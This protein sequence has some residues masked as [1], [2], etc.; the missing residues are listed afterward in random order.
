MISG[1]Y[2]DLINRDI[3]G[4][5]TPS[6]QA[7][8]R[9]YL[10]GNA[11]ARAYY[12]ELVQVTAKLRSVKAVNPPADLKRSIMARIA[13]SRQQVHVAPQSE[14][15]WGMLTR[16]FVPSPATWMTAGAFAGALAVVLV[17]S[18]FQNTDTPLT[19]QTGG[20]MLPLESVEPKAIDRQEILV[21]SASVVIE[22]QQIGADLVA[23][24]QVAGATAVKVQFSF[25]QNDLLINGIENTS[26]G[27]VNFKKAGN[28]VAFECAGGQIVRVVFHN[29]TDADSQLRVAI[30]QG[31]AESTG[32]FRTETH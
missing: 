16:W 14:S 27:T 12:N 26:G 23:V 22:T 28:T 2:S 30:S 24:T 31:D 3:D 6:E 21:G 25:D 10:A 1:K 13:G 15:Y 5:I 18:I 8:L 17:F 20:S 9:Q 19:G 11:E 32:E 7:E 4:V 29:L